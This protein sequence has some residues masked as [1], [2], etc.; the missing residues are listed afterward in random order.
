MHCNRAGYPG[1]SQRLINI[2]RLS[3]YMAENQA[4]TLTFKQQ[5]ILLSPLIITNS[6]LIG[7]YFYIFGWNIPTPLLYYVFIFRFLTDILPVFLVHAQYL[8]K[9][10]NGV[11]IFDTE[12]R[13]LQHKRS[14]KL[15]EYSFSDIQ[16][17]HY[18][19]SYGRGTG[20]YSFETYRYFRIIFNDQ[21]EIIV[22]CL[23][24]SK[25]GKKI[26]LLLGRKAEKHL[27]LLA[28]ISERQVN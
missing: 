5:L 20:W 12:N 11:I 18:Y 7:I 19:V 8:V 2:L 14:G 1:G 27:M 24:M 16:S 17:L 3:K 22:T 4:Y 28:L 6:I 10:W 26:E 21:S 9:N 23:M 15:F 25:I 13:I